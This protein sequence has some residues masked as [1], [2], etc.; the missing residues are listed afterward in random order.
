M[1]HSVNSNLNPPVSG[2]RS[3]IDELKLNRRGGII[4]WN[5]VLLLLIAV[6]AVYDLKSHKIPNSLIMTGFILGIGMSVVEAGLGGLG[7]FFL[8]VLLVTAAFFLLFLCRMMGAGDIKLIALIC[9]YMGLEGGGLAIA[10]S[11]LAAAVYSLAKLLYHHILFQR[12]FYFV[13]YIRQLIQTKQLEV[14]YDPQRD[15]YEITVPFALFL[16]LGTAS[17]LLV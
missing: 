7:S 3:T 11:F 9:G 6:S 14:Y 16:L 13:A 1:F 2:N 8:R 17:S 12:L 15:G 5:M 10:C 4:I